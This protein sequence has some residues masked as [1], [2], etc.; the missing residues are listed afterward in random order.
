SKLG[1]RYL[2]L[3]KLAEKTRRKV[4]IARSIND[5]FKQRTNDRRAYGGTDAVK[6]RSWLM[7]ALEKVN[8]DFFFSY[9]SK[10]AM[11]TTSGLDGIVWYRGK[12]KKVE[13][14]Y[15]YLPYAGVG[16]ATPRYFTVD[17]GQFRL[18]R[19][20]KNPDETRYLFIRYPDP[21]DGDKALI[22]IVDLKTGQLIEDR[23]LQFKKLAAEV[24]E[25][26]D[27][28]MKQADN[29]EETRL[30]LQGLRL[31]LQAFIDGLTFSDSFKEDHAR[32]SNPESLDSLLLGTQAYVLGAFNQ[33]LA[34]VLN[35]KEYTGS[36]N[37][38][39]LEMILRYA[40]HDGADK[41]KQ[42]VDRLLAA[43][44]LKPERLLE[45][46]ALYLMDMWPGFDPAPLPKEG[47]DLYS[48]KVQDF[49]DRVLLPI[50]DWA[51]GKL[52]D[53]TSEHFVTDTIF[54]ASLDVV[55]DAV[56]SQ[57]DD[58]LAHQPAE[59]VRKGV[60]GLENR[61][62][63]N[64][65]PVAFLNRPDTKEMTSV[66]EY[67][68]EQIFRQ[69]Q[70]A[71]REISE[72]EASERANHHTQY[73]AGEGIG[74]SSALI[75][76]RESSV[77]LDAGVMIDGKN[78]RP[79]WPAFKKE[80][81]AIILSHAH[82][83][84]VGASLHL[85]LVHLKG[86]VPTYVTRGTYE[87]L[88]TQ[89]AGMRD[90][91]SGRA[92]SPSEI[93]EFMKNVHVLD[94]NQWYEITPEMK[95]YLHGPVGHLHGAA[96]L[97][98]ST[99]DSTSF[100]SADISYHAQGPVPGW[101]DVPE[102][103]R[104]HIDR[105]VIESTYGMASRKDED[106]E[107]QRF[108]T[109]IK[110]RLEKGG[111][112]LIPAFAN[113]RSQRAL[114]MLLEN[115]KELANGSDLKIYVDG[116]AAVYTKIY[117]KA[118]PEVFAPYADFIKRNLVLI[119]DT[120][121]EAYRQ[122]EEAMDRDER[123]RTIIISSSGNA[124]QGRSHWWAARLVNNP[125][126][127]IFFTGY[128][129]PEEA[130][131]ILLSFAKDNRDRSA[132]Q[133]R[134]FFF[135]EMGQQPVLALIDEFTLSGHIGGQDMMKIL[136]TLGPG[137]QE[138][139]IQHGNDTRRREVFD[140]IRNNHPEWNPRL[141]KNGIRYQGALPLSLST[142]AERKV[143]FDSLDAQSLPGK[144]AREKK[145]VSVPA[146]EQPPVELSDTQAAAAVPAPAAEAI[147]AADEPAQA[148]LSPASPEVAPAVSAI[149]ADVLLD[150]VET[151][152]VAPVALPEATSMEISS[153]TSSVAE[154]VPPLAAVEAPPVHPAEEPEPSDVSA[155]AVAPVKKAASKT[156][157]KKAAA[158]KAKSA[159]PNT[160]DLVAQLQASKTIVNAIGKLQNKDLKILA[161]LIDALPDDASELVIEK[162]KKHEEWRGKLSQAARDKL[163]AEFTKRS[164]ARS[165]VREGARSGEPQARSE[166]RLRIIFAERIMPIDWTASKVRF[167]LRQQ[168]AWTD[169]S[170][171][172]A[173]AHYPQLLRAAQ[174]I[175]AGDL[176]RKIIDQRAGLPTVEEAVPILALLK[177]R[178]TLSYVLVSGANAEAVTKL[179]DD[180][181]Q[182]LSQAAVRQRWGQIDLNKLSDRF[183]IETVDAAGQGLEAEL[184]TAVLAQVLS[185][186]KDGGRSAVVSES[187]A[188]SGMLS[189]DRDAGH[190]HFLNLYTP[191]GLDSTALVW[192]SAELLDELTDDLLA[193]FDN[194]ALMKDVRWQ[195]LWSEMQQLLAVGVSA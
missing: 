135:E 37:F 180:L 23:Q 150:Q 6:F 100:I 195:G 63:Q 188:I 5:K 108:V 12:D 33:L 113:G 43:Y 167:E 132:D 151:E 92:Y 123:Q 176:Q 183:S 20:S 70:E 185:G 3:R 149:P 109:T 76:Y 42:N 27:Q 67:V 66:E 175:A 121:R 85:A 117:L 154:A 53:L 189:R 83:D 130:G 75:Q 57:V 97:I 1:R 174:K 122:R 106:A 94:Y 163:S 191:A 110:Q 142:L 140:W 49:L 84:H 40:A 41:A 136:E 90:E 17:E 184:K 162:T 192:M 68:I 146:P 74:A 29:K 7:D 64:Y 178:S 129:D 148:L 147:P 82:L 124:T 26:L 193:Q 34:T 38:A 103:I 177:A 159:K 120:P 89:L 87:T 118:Y 145:A 25:A 72:S 152:P 88:P 153:E 47:G 50:N 30:N 126:N 59:D 21:K 19:P 116:L 55:R 80:P 105:A 71:Q 182:H 139:I 172:T 69:R 13:F 65:K 144:P 168:L 51:H 96:S 48:E 166:V 161:G 9:F 155:A 128:M 31:R 138:V 160:E 39:V 111:K 45:N 56:S 24:Q 137:L 2:N 186:Q 62:L 16:I 4:E 35:S 61:F 125:N 181:K 98:V 15:E 54:S 127:G 10:S 179:L 32:Q 11:S 36:L 156:A 190:Y 8:E 93:A 164:L 18:Y 171:Q 133:K 99:P 91:K 165:E 169:L 107:A 187:Q 112:V 134:T 115:L 79:A 14:G 157:V 119:S 73:G 158:K 141:I 52:N 170:F 44:R 102:E 131:S 86:K 22:D 28:L 81:D 104:K 60:L 194:Q 95:V 58:F 114:L 77:L 173:L 143:F 46:L 101:A 78:T